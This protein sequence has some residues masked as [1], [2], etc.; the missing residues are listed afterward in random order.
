[1]GAH[2]IVGRSIRTGHL[3]EYFA[4]RQPGHVAIDT[5][6]RERL[7]LNDRKS[8]EC[9]RGLVM[10]GHTSLGEGG[11]AIDFA[12]VNVMAGRA[13]HLAHFKTFAGS[14]QSVLVSMYVQGGD[15]IYIIGGGGKFI[16]TI[17]YREKE[18][19]PE[20][21]TESGMAECAG[22]KALLSAK[23][24]GINNVFPHCL[25]GMGLMEAHV[26][27]SGAMAS[28]AINTI[29]YTAFIEYG[30]QI[31][32][33]FRPGIGAMA[34]HTLRMDLLVEIDKIGG[35]P[36]TVAPAIRRTIPGYRQLE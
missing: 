18:G 16:Q 4:G 7:L 24:A 21:L 13:I 19:G 26:I 5:I 3:Q 35:I 2:Q 11:G 36:G 10:A 32:L 34:F 6:S 12:G 15:A 8:A 9:M 23:A 1:M 17:P 28:F 33:F 31:V 29:K 27:R 22:V 14:Q 20:G 30:A 25:A